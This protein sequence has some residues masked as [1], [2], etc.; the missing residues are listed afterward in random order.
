MYR[1]CQVHHGFDGC[2]DKL[3][4]EHH[5]NR[6]DKDG[7]VTRRQIQPYAQKEYNNSN[8]GM[9]PCVVLGIEHIPPAVE[10]VSE[11]GDAGADKG[12]ESHVSQLR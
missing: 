1:A 8:N 11:G 9:Y 7:P 10:R 6:Q 2:V 3:S 4:R 5:C 12:V